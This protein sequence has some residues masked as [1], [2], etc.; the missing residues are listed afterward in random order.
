MSVE[1]HTP[2]TE[3]AAAILQ[4]GDTVT[5]TGYILCGRDAVLPK[6][7][8]MVKEGKV[9]GLVFLCKEMLFSIL[10]SALQVWDLHPVINWRLRVV[11][12]H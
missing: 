7:I 12:N 8:K 9:D 4:V 5:I 11:W 2:I 6:V 1:I 3:E 10:R